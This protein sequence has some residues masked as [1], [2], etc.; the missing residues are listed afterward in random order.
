LKLSKAIE[1]RV[2]RSPD[3]REVEH[4][5][6]KI[7]QSAKKR[8]R[9][10]HFGEIIPETP[11]SLT[12]G[13]SRARDRYG[14]PRFDLNEKGVGDYGDPVPSSDPGEEEVTGLVFLFSFF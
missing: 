10:V 12:A 1:P 5:P 13:P 6:E 7:G 3:F 11:P 4:T 2:A 9:S 8:K 14:S